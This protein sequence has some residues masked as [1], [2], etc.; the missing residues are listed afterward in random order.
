MEKKN[1]THQIG[2]EEE[3]NLEAYAPIR[4]MDRAKARKMGHPTLLP[5]FLPPLAPDNALRKRKHIDRMS[6]AEAASHIRSVFRP[7]ILRPEV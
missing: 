1:A 5:R 6:T 2:E 7:P 3:E 4:S